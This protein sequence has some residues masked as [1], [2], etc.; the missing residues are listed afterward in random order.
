MKLYDYA[1]GY[2]HGAKA[3]E[4]LVKAETRDHAREIFEE[5]IA[6]MQAFTESGPEIFAIL[7]IRQ[8]P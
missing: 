6:D 7:S 5:Q 3:K 8:L 2:L 4:T 1:V